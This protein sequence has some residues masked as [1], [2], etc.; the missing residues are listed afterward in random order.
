MWHFVQHRSGQVNEK[1][2]AARERKAATERAKKEELERKAEDAYWA[3]PNKHIDNKAKRKEDADRAR[4]DLLTRKRETKQLLA[5]EEAGMVSVKKAQ[6]T[7][8]VSC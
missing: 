8:K 7:K 2:A 4:Q 6:P 1:A 5:Q 3:D